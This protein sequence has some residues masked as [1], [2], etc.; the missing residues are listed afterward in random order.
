MRPES[1][2]QVNVRGTIIGGPNVPICLPL[3]AKNRAELLVQATS[4]TSL[5]P[6]LVEWRVDSYDGASNTADTMDALGAVRASINELPLIFTCRIQQ[7]GGA[8]SLP[9][10]HRLELIGAA[11][12][13]GQVDIIDIELCNGPEFIES[14]RRICQE[15]GIPMMLSYHDFRETPGEGFI[16]DTLVQARNIGADIAKI[17]LMPNSYKDVLALMNATLK[18]RRHAV[19]IPIITMA[20]GE[21]GAISRIAGGL[22]GS[23][24]TFAMDQDASAPGQIPIG[25]LRQAMEVVYPK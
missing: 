11:I 3:A 5:T 9:Q 4:A 8:A 23:D 25:L 22:F 7:E 10:E 19:D 16:T 21:M 17:A 6:D 20:M 15:A 2:S 13:S 1:K 12:R 24:M 18:A 14:I